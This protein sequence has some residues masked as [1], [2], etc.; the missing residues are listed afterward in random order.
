MKIQILSDLH[1]EHHRDDGESLIASL[2]FSGADLV[3]LAGDIVDFGINAFRALDGIRSLCAKA[4]VTVLYIPGNHEYYGASPAFVDQNLLILEQQIDN[5]TVL[6]PDVIHVQQGHRFLGDTLW[7]PDDPLNAVY[8]VGMSDFFRIKGF[9]PWV[10]ERH[11][12]CR[13][14]LER[15]LQEGDIVL[16]HHMPSPSLIAP[17]Y[18]GSPLNRFFAADLTDLILERKPALWFCGHTHVS[19]DRALGATRMLCNPHGYPTESQI[20]RFNPHLQVEV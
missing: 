19:I 1:L 3:L 7:F 6:R 16:T 8:A 11:R 18:L 14:F 9:V 15:E 10:Y 4:T 17:Q 12:A 2:N 5:L 13:A 20:E